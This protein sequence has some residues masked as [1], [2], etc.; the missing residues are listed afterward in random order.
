MLVDFAYK[1]RGGDDDFFE[2]WANWIG[3]GDYPIRILAWQITLELVI[4]QPWRG[5]LSFARSLCG[6]EPLNH[7]KLC[8]PMSVSLLCFPMS[9]YLFRIRTVGT[10]QGCSQIN[11]GWVDY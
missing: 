7:P 9:V 3:D 8:F 10:R 2:F 4:L 6:S 11:L 1:I 5:R